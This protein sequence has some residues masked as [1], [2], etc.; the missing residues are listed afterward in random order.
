MSFF[1]SFNKLYYLT[2][3]RSLTKHNVLSS[4]FKSI[5]GFCLS[6]F[7]KILSCFWH[8]F[9]ASFSF[10][11]FDF[12]VLIQ[13]Y[14]LFS[15]CTLSFFGAQLIVLRFS[16]K[17]SALFRWQGRRE[18]VKEWVKFVNRLKDAIDFQ[19]MHG[20]NGLEVR[21]LLSP[22]HRTTPTAVN[23]QASFSDFL[24]F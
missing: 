14:W 3:L 21:P 6:S 17:L 8:C 19:N 9:F 15:L 7:T 18:R 22:G 23:L 4:Y 5:S 1:S 2:F 11:Q 16:T 10:I 20:L 24:P 12:F 13:V